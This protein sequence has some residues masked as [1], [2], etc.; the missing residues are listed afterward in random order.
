[1]FTKLEREIYNEHR[2]WACKRLGIT[3]N[4]Y[5]WLRRKGEELNKIYTANCNGDYDKIADNLKDGVTAEVMYEID[6]TK[7][8]GE[9]YAYLI[10]QKLNTKNHKMY[11]YFQ[12]DP[13]GAS[14][15]IDIEAIP[16]NNYTQAI[17]IY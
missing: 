14:L 11:V 8:E 5:N 2:E 12:T 17:C 16:A 3:K 7:K 9:I 13:R 1:M 15:Y 10:D 4:Q 6:C